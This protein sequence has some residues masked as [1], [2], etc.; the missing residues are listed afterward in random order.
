MHGKGY[1]MPSSHAQFAAYFSISLSL[2]LLLRHQT[3]RHTSYRPSTFLQRISLSAL[4]CICAAFVALSRIYLN[5]HTPRQVW[6]GF[7]AGT[8]FAGVWF[9][10]TTWLRKE[11]WIEWALDLDVVRLFR[12]RDL[13][14]TED[15][16]DAGWGR[17]VERRTRKGEANGRPA[18][19]NKAR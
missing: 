19:A 2:F 16:Q 1:G 8:V 3:T 6:I 7:A 10:F 11:G 15:L 4:A 13:I 12:V 9:A 18:K 17:F 5:Y 14:L